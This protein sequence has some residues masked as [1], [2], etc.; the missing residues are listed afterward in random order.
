MVPRGQRARSGRARVRTSKKK[1]SNRR[2]RTRR[3]GTPRQRRGK[4]ALFT[5]RALQT[6]RL[7]SSSSSSSS[8]APAP[9]QDKPPPSSSAGQQ[10]LK[11][12]E[13]THGEK[14]RREARKDARKKVR[15][16]LKQIRAWKERNGLA[17][18]RPC[19]HSARQARC[20]AWRRRASLLNIFFFQ[21]YIA[22]STSLTPS[23]PHP[24]PLPPHT[25]RPSMAP[26]DSR[27]PPPPR[28]R[29]PLWRERVAGLM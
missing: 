13:N 29:R 2:K 6:P 15:A 14:R 28:T 25:H 3:Q 12:L 9:H 26:D 8:L 19:P 17:A 20:G 7:H 23:P 18:L 5:G 21:F 16:A 11:R 22:N 10:E 1:K 24:R 4:K 27:P